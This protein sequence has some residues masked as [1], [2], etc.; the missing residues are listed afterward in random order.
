MP[1]IRFNTIL[2]DPA[3][4]PQVEYWADVLE[5]APSELKEAYAAPAGGGGS[6]N[7]LRP[8]HLRP[9]VR[10]AGSQLLN[11]VNLLSDQLSA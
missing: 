11:K 10:T 1:R 9:Q 5:V 2:I 8:N 7:G 6:L 3:N 4:S